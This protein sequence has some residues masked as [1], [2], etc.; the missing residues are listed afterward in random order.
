MLSPR[1]RLL[2]G[3]GIVATAVA[4]ATVGMVV[5]VN[6]R[7]DHPSAAPC[8]ISALRAAPPLWAVLRGATVGSYE[9]VDIELCPTLRIRRT[10]RSDVSWVAAGGGRTAV[11]DY[12]GPY[13][14]IAFLDGDIL[15]PVPGPR[16]LASYAPALSDEGDL[17]YVSFDGRQMSLFVRRAGAHETVVAYR[18]APGK[19]LHNPSWN[20][21]GDL[22]VLEGPLSPEP[23]QRPAILILPN[24]RPEQIR[25]TSLDQPD[26]S[27]T[28]Y[29]DNDTLVVNDG[30]SV[31]HPRTTIVDIDTGRATAFPTGLRFLATVPGTGALLAR[32]NA[33]NLVLLDD[34]GYRRRHLLGR[35]GD[36][37]VEAATFVPPTAKETPSP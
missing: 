23:G 32:D 16:M 30:E 19:A 24:G 1:T 10:V 8:P 29:L 2:A 22:A 27:Q 31:P 6:R 26:A 4:L 28:F 37:L 17:A 36:H 34:A 11:V 3:G 12:T 14:R 9:L 15:R 21:R 18:S 20:A 7:H 13:D 35:I 5:A 33:R 25:R